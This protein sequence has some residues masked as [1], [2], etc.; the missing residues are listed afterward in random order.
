MKRKLIFAIVCLV[1]VAVL[2]A[3]HTDFS[4]AWKLNAEK[5]R[6]IGMMAQMTMVQKIEESNAAL[7]VDIQTQFQGRDSE[8]KTHYDLT[9]K[10]ATNE[11]PMSG[12]SETVSRWEGG[13]LVTTWTSESAVAGGPKVVRTETR[14][15]SPDGHTMT[16]ESVRGSGP[17]VVLVFD[18]Q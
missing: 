11:L 1:P 4:G 16:V 3:K 7:D 12:A 10:P 8:N 13:K 5:S 14:S 15:L 18:R 2:A 17:P 6:N 9:G